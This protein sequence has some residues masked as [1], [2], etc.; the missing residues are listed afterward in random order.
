GHFIGQ[1]IFDR[2]KRQ[3]YNQTASDNSLSHLPIII[4]NSEANHQ[5]KQVPTG[6]A[7]K[8]KGTIESISEKLNDFF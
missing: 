3:R 7:S 5:D 1:R 8:N 2:Q 4:K 6:R